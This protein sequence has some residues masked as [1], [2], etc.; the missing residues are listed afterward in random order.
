MAS[1]SWR[2]SARLAVA[3]LVEKADIKT[4]WDVPKLLLDALPYRMQTILIGNGVQFAE[5]PRNRSEILS[6]QMRFDTICDANGIAC[7]PLETHFGL[8]PDTYI[9]KIRS[10]E[11]DRFVLNPTHKVPQLSS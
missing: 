9:G 6:R 7:R 11:P 4:A 2:C 5:R 10:S 3:H 1:A 8:A